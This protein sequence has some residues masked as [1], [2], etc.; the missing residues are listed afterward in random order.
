M[1]LSAASGE[2]FVIRHVVHATTLTRKIAF[3]VLALVL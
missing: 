1:N 2:V 3:V